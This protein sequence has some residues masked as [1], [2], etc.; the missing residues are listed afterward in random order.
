MGYA[1]YNCTDYFNK[2][3]I[4]K[5]QKSIKNHTNIICMKLWELKS[6]ESSTCVCIYMG[7]NVEN[8]KIKYFLS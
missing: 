8:F 6:G 5:I 1:I 7:N 3:K 4:L 2:I